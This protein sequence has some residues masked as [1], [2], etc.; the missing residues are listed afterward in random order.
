[1]PV[2]KEITI[3]PRRIRSPEQV[4]KIRN[5]GRLKEREKHRALQPEIRLIKGA[6]RRAK[7]KNLEFDLSLEDIK[8]P[9]FCPILLIPLY[10]NEKVV[11]SSSPTLDRID[12]SKGYIKGNIAV[13]SHK[14]NSHK[15]DLTLAQSIRLVEYMKGNT[16]T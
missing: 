12:N 2:Y 14:A 1:M 3:Y 13:I 6:K 16:I 5:Y 4:L 10:H 11:C 15:S 9:K 8:I 7:L